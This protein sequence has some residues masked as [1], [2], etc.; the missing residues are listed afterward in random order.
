MQPMVKIIGSKSLGVQPVYDIGVAK[1]HNFLVANRL[2]ASNCFN[3]SHS[4]AYAYVTYQ[5]AFLKANY[6]VEYM[7]ALLTANSGDQ[8]KVTKYLSNCEQT[9]G[10]KVEPPD[11]NRSNINFTPVRGK[12]NILFGLSA[13]KNVGEGAIEAILASRQEGGPFASLADLCQRINLQAVNSRNLESLIKCGAFDGIS[14]NR[15]QLIKDIELIVPWAQKRAKE[16]AVGQANLFDLMGGGNSPGEKSFEAAPKAPVTIDFSSQER[17]QFELELLGVYVSDHP[18]KPAERA[19]RRQHIETVQLREIDRHLRKPVKLVVMLQEVK[20]A[21]TKKDNK[22]MAILKITSIDGMIVPA[23]AFADVYEKVKDLLNV[24]IPILLHGKAGRRDEEL[25]VVVED[26]ELIDLSLAGEDDEVSNDRIALIKIDIE[27]LADERQ[28]QQIKTILEEY[29]GID[30]ETAKTP[31]YALIE[32]TAGKRLVKF[33]DQFALEAEE[34]AIDRI[35]T[36]GFNAQVR[37]RPPE[38]PA[39]AVE[40]AAYPEIGELSES[41]AIDTSIMP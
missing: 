26:I 16:K 13:I 22:S 38:L 9:L 17:L 4:T 29:A 5:T 32:S 30:E 37:S 24:N 18:L 1:D 34:L 25:Q 40:A 39:K 14:I 41:G 6:P 35:A 3:K 28:M 21:Q 31:V 15:Q 11:I 33:G 8:D 36:L 27:T 12:K 10:I 7:A 19:I 2:V 20:I 23:V